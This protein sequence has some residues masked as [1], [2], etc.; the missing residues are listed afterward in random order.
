MNDFFYLRRALAINANSFIR[1]GRGWL[2][3]R[4]RQPW[5]RTTR[6]NVITL[7]SYVIIRI[8]V[9]VLRAIILYT[10][11][12]TTTTGY[13]RA[14][15]TNAVIYTIITILHTSTVLYDF[16]TVCTRNVALYY[17]FIMT[18]DNDCALYDIIITRNIL[19]SYAQCTLH[20]RTLKTN[21]K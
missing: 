5:R 4:T 11:A 20:T 9:C 3:T 2:I 15:L 18:S 1:P 10:T 14:P 8:I 19:L 21:N 13:H 16:T 17:I 6:V 7:V 12:V